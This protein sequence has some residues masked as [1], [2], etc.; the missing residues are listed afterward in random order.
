MWS[1]EGKIS[2]KD[3][4]HKAIEGIAYINNFFLTKVSGRTC[5]R[6]ASASLQQKINAKI[7]IGKL[8]LTRIQ[9][10]VLSHL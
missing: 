10:R 8:Q 2:E 6:L 3:P 9:T 1:M 7:F 5:V 4:G